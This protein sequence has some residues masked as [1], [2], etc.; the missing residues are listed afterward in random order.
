ML[1]NSFDA[2]AVHLLP[3]E[4]LAVR[5]VPRPP[6]VRAHESGIRQLLPKIRGWEARENPG[7]DTR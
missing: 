1:I 4:L 7:L 3:L 2:F 5:G 6:P